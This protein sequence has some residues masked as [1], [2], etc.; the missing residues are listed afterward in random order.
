MAQLGPYAALSAARCARLCKRQPRQAKARQQAFYEIMRRRMMPPL[1]VERR[2][3]IRLV[4]TFQSK[5]VGQ[6]ARCHPVGL[7]A[8]PALI[9][10][11]DWLG[12]VLSPAAQYIGG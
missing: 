4:V 1:R 2:P 7:A 5:R 12:K 6:L 11:R 3:D 9:L 8:I 10:R